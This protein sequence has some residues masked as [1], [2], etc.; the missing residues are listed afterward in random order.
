MRRRIL[1]TA[2]AMAAVASIAARQAAPT[3]VP[4]LWTDRA[5]STWAL[6]VA[7]VNAAPKFYSETEYL[8]RAGR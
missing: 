1:L 8:R 2:I 5:L 3:T 7:G 6:P 4:R